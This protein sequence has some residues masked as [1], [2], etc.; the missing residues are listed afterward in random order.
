M[1]DEANV[2]FPPKN[3]FDILQ[4]KRAKYGMVATDENGVD[5]NPHQRKLK[6]GIGKR[7]SMKELLLLHKLTK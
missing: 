3:N 5:L 4:A 2:L 6:N 1:L 7:L